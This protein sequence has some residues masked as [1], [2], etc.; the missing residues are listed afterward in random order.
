MRSFLLPAAPLAPA[1]RI[2][3]GSKKDDTTRSGPPQAK[4]S[5]PSVLSLTTTHP[6]SPRLDIVV[7]H[8]VAKR[9]KE[10][11]SGSEVEEVAPL[12]RHRWTNPATIT[13]VVGVL[14][15]HGDDHLA[16]LLSKFAATRP[17]SS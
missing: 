3:L 12:K 9:R 1:T 4:Q 15:K 17:L 16:V 7:T 2:S 6:I 14:L 5:V 10:K 11:V 8:T 13:P